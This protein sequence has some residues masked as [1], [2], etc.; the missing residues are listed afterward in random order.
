VVALSANLGVHS[1]DGAAVSI[2]LAKGK[3]PFSDSLFRVDK[4]DVCVTIYIVL[5]HRS[6]DG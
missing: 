1:L 4:A 6:S 5:C 2:S 3:L